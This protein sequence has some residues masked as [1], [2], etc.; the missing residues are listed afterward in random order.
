MKEYLSIGEVARLKNITIKAL[1][2]YE[3]IGILVPAYINEETGY[4]YYKMEQMVVLDFILT[5]LDLGIPLK[6]F[7]AYLEK[8]GTLDIAR[9]LQ[10]GTNMANLE[11]ARIHRTADKLKNM[12]QHLEESERLPAAGAYYTQEF[13]ARFLLLEPL[14]ELYP[15]QKQYTA[16]MTAL[17][18]RIEDGKYISLYKQGLL[19]LT[20]R[21]NTQVFAF[22]E[23][24]NPADSGL[25]SVLP[26]G[27]FKCKCLSPEN[28][29]LEEIPALIEENGDHRLVLLQER[30]GR[31]LSK[32]PFWEVC[33]SDSSIFAL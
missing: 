6:Q 10:D 31:H 33:I 5:C 28:A 23:I 32:G 17:F 15:T 16:S 22:S 7:P 9:I 1:R 18:C 27:T 4:R 14:K 12:S 13:P 25:T 21:E 30:Y 20:Q 24:A 26:A 11:I 19:Y 29:W 2:Y 3:K 8:D